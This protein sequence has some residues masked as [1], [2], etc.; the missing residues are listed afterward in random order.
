MFAQSVQ[1]SLLSL[2]SS[3]GSDPLALFA[4]HTDPDLPADSHIALL[5]DDSN[6]PVQEDQSLDG[7]DF[8]SPEDAEGSQGKTIHPV[9][10]IQSPTLTT[11]YIRSPPSHQR[12]G[13]K[14]PWLHLQ[15]RNLGRPWSIEFG[16]T[17]PGGQS[18]VVRCS[19]F[20]AR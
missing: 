13:I 7:R 12:L 17:D 2:F 14:L 6:I 4:I 3:V 20:Q 5:H 8:V 19:T 1:P 18:G 16:V 15:V 10:N 9:L 11:T